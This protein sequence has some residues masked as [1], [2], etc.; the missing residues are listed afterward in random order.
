MNGQNQIVKD[1]QVMEEESSVNVHDIFV[2]VIK[3][4]YWFVLSISA[5]LTVAAVYLLWAPK[6]YE[7]T[8]TVLIKD[9]KASTSETA[10]FQDLSIFEGKSNVNNEMIVFKSYSLM[11]EAI[12]RLK[13]NNSYTMRKGLRM[14]ELYT[15]TPVVFTFFDI[16]E[17][18]KVSLRAK[19]LPDNQVE[20]WNFSSKDINVGQVFVANL[21][22]TINTPLGKIVVTPTLWYN[23]TWLGKTI[24]IKKANISSVVN[25]YRNSMIVSLADKQA[26]V[27]NLSLKDVSTQRAEDIL[28][29]VIAIYNEEAI[30]DKNI[31]AVNTENFISERLDI[32]ENELGGVDMKIQKYKTEHRL[33]D[34]QSDAQ[35]ALLE[36]SESDKAVIA[37]QNQHSMAVYI[38]SYLSDPANSTELIPANTGVDDISVEGQILNYNQTLLKRNRLIE[39]SSERNPVVQDLNNSLNAMR[40]NIM[41]AVDN[42]IVN[43]DIQLRSVVA[44]TERTRARISAVPQ[45]QSEV[46]SISR[47]QKIKEELY[48]YLLNKREENAL[49]KAITESTARII[50]AA[51]GLPNPIAPRASILMIAAFLVGIAI[52]A[53]T[54][55]F[56]TS[57]NVT[58]RGRKD[59]TSVLSIPFLGEIPL[60]RVK[61]RIKVEGVVVKES[62][63]DPVS[64]AFRIIRTNMD[65]MRVKQD[66]IKVITTT[67]TNI[68]SGKT[69][70]AS[71]LAVSLAMTGKKVL[72]IDMDIRKGTLGKGIDT[73]EDVDG[74]NNVGL[75]SYLSK[76]ITEVD[77]LIVRDEGYPNVDIICSGPEPPNPA[78]LLLSPRLDE[79]INELR[80]IYDYIVIDNVPAGMIADAL[81]SNRVVDLTLYII[82]AGKLDRRMLPDIEQI[83][84]DEKLKNMAVILNGVGVGLG[85]GYEHGYGYGYGKTTVKR[86]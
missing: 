19:F 31:M 37:L 57:A 35:L 21:N 27:V 49:N 75:T 72:L 85:Y 30:N 71:N 14:Q 42:L 84:H 76:I 78:E 62:G 58:V 33:T 52:P 53:A 63:R 60:K 46:T 51:T 18:Q 7:R 5:C 43:L 86:K 38:R 66:E 50:D 1:T 80:G 25:Y 23:E 67:S 69:F 64:E 56:L 48:L 41:R 68:S 10:L 15:N 82:R 13:V 29:T 54:I 40:Q 28:N 17:T 36:S 26:S 44:R 39:N 16:E 3:M 6:I 20:L 22:D 61:G 45:Q 11:A 9:D 81:I 4:W 83:Y 65:F 77:S 8:A 12:R 47:E 74:N 79:L 34:I 2:L 59:I 24:T 55:Y 32:I 70:V 73:H